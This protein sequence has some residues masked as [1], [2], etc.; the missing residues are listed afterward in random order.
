M[1]PFLTIEEVKE[2]NPKD[3]FFLVYAVSCLAESNKLISGS[4][5][6]LLIQFLSLARGELCSRLQSLEYY[7][8]VS[9]G[10]MLSGDDYIAHD[11]I[12]IK[13]ENSD[14]VK[15]ETV[16]QPPAPPSC[17]VSHFQRLVRALAQAVC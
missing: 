13:P 15:P 6:I 4:G 9:D 1:A 16:S 10:I 5:S 7:S 2:K 14:I 3:F 11:L 8:S 12:L 17:S